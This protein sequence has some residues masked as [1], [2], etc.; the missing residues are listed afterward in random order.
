MT[1]LMTLDPRVAPCRRKREHV[2]GISSETSTESKLGAAS[3][4]SAAWMFNVHFEESTY[5]SPFLLI[6]FSTSNYNSFSQ[7]FPA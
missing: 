4:V 3:S 5:F 1:A 6:Y 7:K 2:S